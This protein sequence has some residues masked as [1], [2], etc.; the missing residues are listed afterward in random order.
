[1]QLGIRLKR[2]CAAVLLAPLSL[3]CV[4][5]TAEEMK[6]EPSEE[7]STLMSLHNRAR[8]EG[9]VCATQTLKAPALAWNCALTEAATQHAEQMA[10]RE[11]LSHLSADGTRFSERVTRAGF[12]WL[13][14]AENIGFAY[15]DA[16]TAHHA[17]SNSREHC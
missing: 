10:K 8:S 7:M 12:N 13:A 16:A 2:L 11:K 1:M 14:V 15:Q 9:L 17:W 4:I 3:N 5:A 6:C